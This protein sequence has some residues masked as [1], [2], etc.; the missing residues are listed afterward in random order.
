MKRAVACLLVVVACGAAATARA[1]TGADDP[2]LRAMIEELKRRTALHLPTAAAPYFIGY[3]VDD[4]YR[5]EAD[6]EFGALTWSNETHRRPAKIEVRVG[7]YDFDSSEFVRQW[8]VPDPTR[9]DL[10]LA[11]DVLALRRE[12]WLGTDAAYKLALEQL[13][14]K[15]AAIENRVAD[16]SVPDFSRETPVTALGERADGTFDLARWAETTRRLSALFRAYPAI[17][18]SEVE[19]RV[20]L[21]THYFANSEG[22]VVRTP[23]TLVSLVATAQT[24]AAD[25]SDVDDVELLIAPD[26][27]SLPSEAVLTARV[28]ALA[29]RV[30]DLVAAPLMESYTGPVLVADQAAGE[31]FGQ[32]F[33]TNLSGQR[34]PNAQQEEREATAPQSEYMKRVGRFVLPAF[35]S[36]TDDPAATSY[37]SERLMGTYAYDDQGVRAEKLDI[38]TDGKL[39]TLFLSRRPR[40]ATDTQSNGRARAANGWPLPQASNLFVTV[41]PG[42]ARTLQQ[43]TQQMLDLCRA[44]DLPYGLL[45]TRIATSPESYGERPVLA[46]PVLAYRVWASDGHREL[47]RGGSFGEVGV[48]TF[49]DILAASDTPVVTHRLSTTYNGQVAPAP[50]VLD[51]VPSSVIAPAVLVEE[52]EIRPQTGGR[53][54]PPAL[55]HP[56]FAEKRRGR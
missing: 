17:D 25:G 42:S 34:P 32:I 41:A 40:S 13:A 14:S 48:R 26:A 44:Q 18:D 23:E 39:R 54:K 30:T 3:T 49:K 22:A 15:R 53:E 52:L 11:D 31:L 7:S 45:I 43:L 51:A 27:A 4:E 9:R 16:D 50:D 5:Y 2:L 1:T 33:A 35:V 36:I 12:L 38:V 20:R 37:G 21:I 29:Q 56:Y 55:R 6:A 8:A 47:V 24:R 10:P 19:L 28:R 46:D